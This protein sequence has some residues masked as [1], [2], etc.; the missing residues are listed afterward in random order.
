VTQTPRSLQQLVD[1]ARS[2]AP[3]RV[4][5]ADADQGLVIETMRETQEQGWI[6]PR[7]VGVS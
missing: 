2:L 5:V 7:L 6:E 1:K 4:A 3:I